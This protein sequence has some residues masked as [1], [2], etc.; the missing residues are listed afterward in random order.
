MPYPHPEPLRYPSV[1]ESAGIAQGRR[2]G[3][4]CCIGIDVVSQA[5]KIKADRRDP[6]DK[7]GGF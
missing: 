7:F 2:D 4:C 5:C 1:A 3:P 6:E